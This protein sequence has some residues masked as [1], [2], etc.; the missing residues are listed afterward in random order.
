MQHMQQHQTVYKEKYMALKGI[1]GEIEHLQ[2]LLEKTRKELQRDFEQW[3]KTK[4]PAA[5]DST[6]A[7][8]PSSGAFGATAG[9]P[10]RPLAAA[11]GVGA[12]VVTPAQQMSL[13]GRYLLFI[14][15]FSGRSYPFITQRA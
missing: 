13:T 4:A 14:N 7:S 1:K 12:H 2:L 8:P 5:A 6:A 11:A 3:W 9:M 10:P 15:F